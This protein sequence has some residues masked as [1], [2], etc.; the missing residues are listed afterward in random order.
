MDKPKKPFYGHTS[1]HKHSSIF[2]PSQK[3]KFPF[4]LAQ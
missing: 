4:H 3:T 1:S 2:K